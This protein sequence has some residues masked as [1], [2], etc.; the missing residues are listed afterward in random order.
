MDWSIF[1]KNSHWKTETDLKIR[2]KTE[3]SCEEALR[4]LKLKNKRKQKFKCYKCMY[5]DAFHINYKTKMSH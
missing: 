4:Y 5:C 1:D 2:Y 3:H